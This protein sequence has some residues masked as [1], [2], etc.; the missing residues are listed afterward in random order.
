[1]T[2][3]FDVLTSD[4]HEVKQLL[5]K[6]EQGRTAAG[7]A[8]DE[9]LGQRKKTVERLIIE[10][11]KHEAV[12]EEYFWPAVRQK[13]PDGD[14]LADEATGQEQEAK[15][16][17][18]RID[19][20]DPHETEFE[21]LLA[22]FIADAR[23]HIDFEESRVWPGLRASLSAEEAAELGK[24]LEQGKQMAP[25][26]PHPNTPPKPGV[27]KAAGPAVAAADRIR[28]AVTGRGRQ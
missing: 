19:K 22:S 28:D 27:L 24:K 3:V 14:R 20:L 17:L 1:M 4:H 13:H 6:L 8:S 25:T 15:Q 12:E 26:R 21:K 23:E 5:A 7:G 9:A 10:E 18:D 16:V 11:S 2:D